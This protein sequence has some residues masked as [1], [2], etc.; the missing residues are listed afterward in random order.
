MAST[1]ERVLVIRGEDCLEPLSIVF[2][3]GGVTTG[4]GLEGEGCEPT[5]EFTLDGIGLIFGDSSILRLRGHSLK[6]CSTL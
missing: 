1:A 3:V 4:A 6:R 5:G 2:D